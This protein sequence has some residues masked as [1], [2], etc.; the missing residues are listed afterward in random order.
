MEPL[1]RPVKPLPVREAFASLFL[2]RS[3]FSRDDC[4][5]VT[6]QF[7]KMVKAGVLRV[8]LE[9]RARCGGEVSGV[10]AGSKRAV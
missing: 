1:V 4:R 3:S 6:E 10:F 5:E 2:P 7:S 9:D 8:R